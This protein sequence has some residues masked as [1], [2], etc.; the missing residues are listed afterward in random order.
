MPECIQNI[1]LGDFM[2]PFN[3]LQLADDSS[4]LADN[5]VSLHTKME[6][7]LDYADKKIIYVNMEKTKYIEF[8]SNPSLND[9]KIDT[10]LVYL[11]ICLDWQVCSTASN[12]TTDFCLLQS[13]LLLHNFFH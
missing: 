7:I 8:N 3:I 2:D 12:L 13:F 5:F 4:I 1:Q 11:V 10:Y 9:I 6:K